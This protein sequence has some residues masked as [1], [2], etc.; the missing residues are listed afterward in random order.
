MSSRTSQIF[1]I[2][3][4]VIDTDTEEELEEGEIKEE[5]EEGEIREKIVVQWVVAPSIPE[6]ETPAPAPVMRRPKLLETKTTKCWEKVVNWCDWELSD[7]EED[8][9]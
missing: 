2:N 4:F 6:K 3:R 7:D 8:N 9:N 1:V 5:L